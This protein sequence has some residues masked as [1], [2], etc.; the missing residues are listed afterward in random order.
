MFEYCSIGSGSSGNCHLIKY[1]NSV[2]L[3]DAGLVGKKISNGLDDL[4]IDIE[5]LKGIFITHEHS[6]HIKGVGIISR[7]YNIPVFAN[8]NTWHAMKDKI[9]KIDKKNMVVF[10]SDKNYSLGEMIIRPF[11]IP[12]D[13][14]EAVGY[15]FYANGE[16]ISIATDIGMINEN[17][18]KNLYKSKLVV[19]ESNYDTNMLMVGSYPYSLKQRVLSSGGHLSN[20]D[21]GNFCVELVKKGTEK[22]LLA[23]I[24]RENNFKELAFETTKSILKDNNI[25]VGKDVFLDV[26]PRDNISNLYNL[27]R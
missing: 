22:I 24:S 19:V 18:R 7:K 10:Q 25:T 14:S 20:E 2:V 1:K 11:S 17:I 26:L 12:H 21:C 13:S 4:N 5:I 3:V 27:E 23:H 8:L 6:D 15:S 9:G 16:K